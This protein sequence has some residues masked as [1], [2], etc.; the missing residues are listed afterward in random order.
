MGNEHV[1]T[2]RAS[3]PRPKTD[4]TERERKRAKDY[5]HVEDFIRT[6]GLPCDVT[7]FV[8]GLG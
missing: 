2:S 8:G 3:A 4:V 5:L 1:T 6:L 7:D